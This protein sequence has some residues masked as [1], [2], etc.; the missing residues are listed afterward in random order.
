[1]MYLVEVQ[2]DNLSHILFLESEFITVYPWLN[3]SSITIH[4]LVRVSLNLFVV[5][6]MLDQ[7]TS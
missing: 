1:M 2:S 7:N 6:M 5:T 3:S 4:T